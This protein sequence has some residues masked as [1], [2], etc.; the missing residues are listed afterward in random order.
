[1]CNSK[2]VLLSFRSYTLLLFVFCFFSSYPVSL[3]LFL[4]GMLV[5]T[6]TRLPLITSSYEREG[7]MPFIKALSG[8]L[9]LPLFMGVLERRGGSGEAGGWYLDCF[10]QEVSNW[11]PPGF[12]VNLMPDEHLVLELCKR[13]LGLSPHDDH[14]RQWWSCLLTCGRFSLHTI[15]PPS[16]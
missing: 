10:Y 12:P 16:I 2:R 13:C 6:T 5:C 11:H 1:V 7:Q 9:K 3:W 14:H 8:C 4:H 15:R